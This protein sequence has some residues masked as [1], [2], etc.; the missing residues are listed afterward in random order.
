MCALLARED[1][2]G[3]AGRTTFAGILRCV[4]TYWNLNMYLQVSHVSE[5]KTGFLSIA[6]LLEFE[7]CV[8][9]SAPFQNINVKARKLSHCARSLDITRSLKIL[10]RKLS[11]LSELENLERCLLLHLLD[12]LCRVL[13][14]EWFALKA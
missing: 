4:C 13:D 11:K 12:T 6:C 1:E 5:R 7:N 9:V 10:E 2:D 14:V 3:E 8:V